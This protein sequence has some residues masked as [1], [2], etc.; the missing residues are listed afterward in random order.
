MK[1]VLWRITLILLIF[2]VP[3]L[4][5]C[6][7]IEAPPK[8][9][10]A[11]T[12]DVLRGPYL[13]QEQVVAAPEG[14]DELYGWEKVAA[15]EHAA[16]LE[17]IA[18]DSAAELA[19]YVNPQALATTAWLA[20][21]LDDPTVRVLDVRQPT[22][23]ANFAVAHIPNAQHVDLM[24]DLMDRDPNRVAL[25]LIGPERFAALMGRLGVANDAT[26]V[27][28][29]SEGGTAAATLWWAL[30]YYGHADVRMLNGGLVKWLIEG[31]ETT[32]TVAHFAP[33]EYIINVQPHLLATVADVELAMHD[34]AVFV[35]DARDV[36]YF[37][38]ARCLSA[39]PRA[40]HIPGALMMPAR[41]QVTP[42][43]KMLLPA[44]RLAMSLQL[45]GVTPTQRGIT[46]CGN[47]HL[48]AFDAFLLYVMGF[49]DVAVYDSAWLEWGVLP[50]MPVETGCPDC[51][52]M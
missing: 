41:W 37:T 43:T 19:G 2:V 26:I 9:T 14:G 13:W 51:E 35:V 6:Q 8:L 40:G 38:G 1:H 21:H 33:T 11:S 27:V 52:A 10:D 25:D 22:G 50:D 47:G 49:E 34:P 7:P 39:A 20:A 3:L 31:R 32:H 24:V 45:M 16:R 36:E 23:A 30:R 17:Q 18:L 44:E 48:A 28:Y 46:Y 42:D 4:A 29:D 5:G 15:A 12:A